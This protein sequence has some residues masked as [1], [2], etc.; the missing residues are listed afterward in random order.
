[1]VHGFGGSACLYYP[2]Y[3]KLLE[4]FRIV[5]IDMLGFGASSRV[6]IREE[7]LC[8]P[9]ATDTYQ[10]SWLQAWLNQMSLNQELP[11]KFYLHGHSYGG[12]LSSL[13]ACA[14]P[15]RIAA[16][17]LNSTIGAEPEPSEYNFLN[18]RLRSGAQK[19]E[20]EMVTRLMKMQW[21]NQ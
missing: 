10:L 17:F 3:K 4:H 1:M 20:P 15:D 12:Y 7:V 16:L 19:P 5:A 13:L 21:E 18:L 8:S 9:S 6:R 11:E 2:I 14:N